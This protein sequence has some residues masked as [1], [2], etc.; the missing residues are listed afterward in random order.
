[1]SPTRSTVFRVRPADVRCAAVE[2]TAGLNRGHHGS[3]ERQGVRFDLRLV[4]ASRIGERVRADLSGRFG[5]R[6]R[7]RGRHQNPGRPPRGPQQTAGHLCCEVSWPGPSIA[8]ETTA[9][10]DSPINRRQ[11]LNLPPGPRRRNSTYPDDH[12]A[13]TL[14]QLVVGD[15]VLS[16]TR[17]ENGRPAQFTA[18][19]VVLTCRID[20]GAR[21][22]PEKAAGH[23]PT[24]PQNRGLSESASWRTA[25]N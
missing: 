14:G 21:C 10:G 12:T 3:P 8:A 13:Q 22:G 9:A 16:T 11:D 24:S 18:P 7:G 5:G 2:E 20:A 1:V 17:R 6:G 4:L 19:R 25:R 23:R 15:V